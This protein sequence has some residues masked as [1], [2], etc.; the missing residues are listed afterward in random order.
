VRYER[1]LITI[2][3]VTGQSPWLRGCCFSKRLLVTHQT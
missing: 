3:Y 1:R 2:T